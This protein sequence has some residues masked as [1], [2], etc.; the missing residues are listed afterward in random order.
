MSFKFDKPIE[1]PEDADPLTRAYITCLNSTLVFRQQPRGEEAEAVQHS[2]TERAGG[3]FVYFYRRGIRSISNMN[4]AKRMELLDTVMDAD[5]EN[6]EWL[7]R[8]LCRKDEDE[9]EDE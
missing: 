5:E 8:E 9:E 6:L 2:H 4:H 1:I 3:I 7:H